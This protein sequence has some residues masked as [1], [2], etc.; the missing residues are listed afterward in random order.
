MALKCTKK[1]ENFYATL[2]MVS[3]KN[4]KRNLEDQTVFPDG[5]TD[6][7]FDWP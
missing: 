5:V 3:I 2:G 1:A 4:G 6:T 7:N